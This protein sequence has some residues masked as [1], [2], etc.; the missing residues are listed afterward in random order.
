VR[1]CALCLDGDCVW[2][3]RCTCV[4]VLWVFLYMCDCV[5][6]GDCMLCACTFLFRV[7]IYFGCVFVYMTVV[8]RLFG[9]EC[10]CLFVFE[11]CISCLFC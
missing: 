9:E 10:L 2:F 1:L 11:A 3:V 8:W 4:C 5:F 7:F 6:C